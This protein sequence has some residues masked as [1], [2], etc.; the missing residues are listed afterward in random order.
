MPS[1]DL[2]L[3]LGPSVIGTFV[4]LFLN[5]M[6]LVQ[7]YIYFTQHR[8]DPKW[9]KTL[10]GYTLI[11]DSTL[12]IIE[13]INA[14]TYTVKFFGDTKKIDIATNSYSVTPILTV[15]VTS[16]VQIYFAWR[17]TKLTLSKF[18]GSIVVLFSLVQVLGGIGTGAGMLAVR[19]IDQFPKFMSTFMVWFSASVVADAIIAIT[20]C[21]YLSTLNSSFGPT[22]DF[23]TRLIRISGTTGIF[24]L[25]WT[26]LDLITFNIGEKRAVHNFFCMTISKIYSNFLL[27]SLN[28]RKVITA[29]ANMKNPPL[30]VKG[31]AGVGQD[32]DFSCDL[33]AAVQGCSEIHSGMTENTLTDSFGK[34]DTK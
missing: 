29:P 19:R 30:R 20:L 11:A 3:T 32:S 6:L 24:T 31:A 8:R 13:C 17:V 18:L 25:I 5:G 16:V 15:A 7:C 12:T 34:V 9:L 27:I 22:N 26:I 21:R 10:V 23:I 2:D 4:S 14:Y 28:A 33:E 1:V